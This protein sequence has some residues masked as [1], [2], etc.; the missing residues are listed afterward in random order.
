MAVNVST[1]TAKATS[2]KAISTPHILSRA[3]SGDLDARLR[4]LAGRGGT[5]HP[6]HRVAPAEVLEAVR[7]E[8]ERD[9]GAPVCGEGQHVGDHP[10]VREHLRRFTERIDE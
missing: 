2:R 4:G 1:T 6:E 3:R 10:A 7:A 8:R 5:G 9:E